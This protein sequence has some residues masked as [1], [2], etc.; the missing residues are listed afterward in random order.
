MVLAIWCADMPQTCPYSLA[1]FTLRFSFFVFHLLLLRYGV[2][3]TSAPGVAS[4]DALDGE[5]KSTD[6]TVLAYGFNGVLRAGGGVAA[7][8]GKEG[9]DAV[10]V[11]V[12]GDEE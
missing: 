6:G 10:A 7:G 12:D 11:E 3:A 1:L 9:R 5:P 2:V 8:G 4:E